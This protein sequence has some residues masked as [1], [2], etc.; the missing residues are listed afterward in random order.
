MADNASAALPGAPT[1]PMDKVDL[2]DLRETFADAIE[3]VVFDGQ[4][5]R[6]E[7]CV[8]RLEQKAKA[9]PRAKR[10]PACRL[11]LTPN[12]AVE[13]MKQMRQ[14]ASGLANAGVGKLPATNRS[15][16][17]PKTK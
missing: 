10:Y 2:P 8:T 9:P 7:F 15:E 11:V 4:S 13:L 14:L 1:I 6:I 5:M 12:A 16:V 3:N 17:D